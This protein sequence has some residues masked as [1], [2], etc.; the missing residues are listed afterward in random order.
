MDGRLLIG[1]ILV[2]A[3][4]MLSG[5]A[6]EPNDGKAYRLS[7]FENPYAAGGAGGS[8]SEAATA[9]TTSTASTE[10][11]LAVAGE[12]LPARSITHVDANPPTTRRVF[13]D[14]L[15]GVFRSLCG[16]CHVEGNQG[17]WQVSRKTFNLKRARESL[18]AMSDDRSLTK[19][20]PP[21]SVGGKLP[22]DR[23]ADDPSVQ[24]IDMLRSYIRGGAM[25]YSY[26]EDFVSEGAASPYRMA[27][28]LADS[29]T[30]LGNCVPDKGL[31]ATETKEMEVMDDL[32]ASAAPKYT[33]SVVEQIGLP[34][35]L[36]ETDLTSFDSAELAK[37]GVVAWT[38]NYP[39]FNDGARAIRHV[40][41]PLGEA[42]TFDKDKQQFAIPDLTRFYKTYLKPVVQSDGSLHWRKMETQLIV[43]WQDAT[44]YTGY[45]A[46]V[47]L[48]GS[49]LW[50]EDE[51]EA[52]LVT[53]PLRDGKA[54]RDHLLTYTSDEVAEA[55]VLKLVE[56]QGLADPGYR[57]NES[58]A[59]HRYAVPGARRCTE[60]HQ[61]SPSKNFVL[62]F[63]P[64]QLKRHAT[65]SNGV[66]EP[67]GE[68]E[69]TQ[70]QR[71]IDYGLL[72]GLAS[73]DDIVNLEDSQ[74]SRKP[75]NN[76]ELVAQGYVMSACAHCHNDRGSATEYNSKLTGA[77]DLQPGTGDT[78]GIFQFPLDRYSE[79][80][81]RGGAEQVR[82]PYITPSLFDRPS[83]LV[84]GDI[85]RPKCGMQVDTLY[86]RDEK[87]T[88]E[89]EKYNPILGTVSYGMV[90]AL[91][92]WRSL[93]YRGVDTPFAYSD[94]LALFPRMPMHTP[95][96]DC[97]APRV[98]AEW[99]ISIPSTNG[100]P[101]DNFPN[102]VGFVD[103][104]GHWVDADLMKRQF[105]EQP[106]VEVKPDEDGFEKAQSL[107]EK[108]LR[109]Y[110]GEETPT[111]SAG[112]SRYTFCPE[113]RDIVDRDVLRDPVKTPVPID[114]EAVVGGTSHSRDNVPNTVHW[115]IQD[116]TL[117]PG[118]WYPRRADWQ[119][120]LQARSYPSGTSEDEKLVVKT[121]QD[122]QLTDSLQFFAYKKR[123]MALW[124]K[125]DNCSF[126]GVP[127]VAS[128][129]TN[130]PQWM[131]L[132]RPSDSEP[133]YRISPGE[134][135]NGLVCAHCHGGKG[136]A[137]GRE[138]NTLNE[139]TG[140]NA[141]VTNF[142]V[143]ISVESNR[144]KVFA[145]S[146]NVSAED[147]AARYFAWMGLG[148][149]KQTIPKSILSLVATTE[150]IG[151]KRG[152]YKPPKDANM[153][154]APRD[155]CRWTLPWDNGNSNVRAEVT[156][157]TSTKLR[158]LAMMKLDMDRSPLIRTNGDEELWHQLC[159][160]D[161]PRPVRALHLE[162][163]DTSNGVEADWVY[164]PTT[165]LY[166]GAVYPP[167]A[168][169]MDHRGNAAN[170]LSEGNLS[171]WCLR[172]PATSKGRE[173][174]DEW[175]QSHPATN[176]ELIPY[177]PKCIVCPVGK[178]CPAS[179]F[180]EAGYDPYILPFT[181]DETS[182][183]FSPKDAH[184]TTADLEQ[185]AVRGAINAGLVAFEHLKTVAASSSVSL[186]PNHDQ[187]EQL[188]Q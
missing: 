134:Y 171:P 154:S 81:F 3:A 185:W 29:L 51:T 9:G 130:K 93:V 13:V 44:G 121:L 120:I 55:E 83:T 145:S 80:I 41:V 150:A 74:G 162:L 15:F 142:L 53:D 184:L 138:A 114:K 182:H 4:S 166:A 165:S 175:R 7:D 45:A 33:G 168:A 16:S 122:V 161:N 10:C 179:A 69:L 139:M 79:S 163:T 117:V 177:C 126:S 98:M 22:Q 102:L 56:K 8:T 20:M 131:E 37:R 173:F 63:Q 170:G 58:S 68:D 100:D 148:G 109:E 28:E 82:I 146:G 12:A 70:V 178:S 111:Y 32:F 75:R 176:G 90:C 85:W 167:T 57:L 160:I 64:L 24:L 87:L 50:N 25:P 14:D 113:N 137:T 34:V 180:C 36:K 46:V 5:C 147:W 59:V 112:A 88:L 157:N 133:V 92:P 52:R 6:A 140:G 62:G 152:N 141:L 108:R 86:V 61:G 23:K 35:N 2:W 60:C 73:E 97:Q 153:L 96:F 26:V 135:V 187:C 39:V 47:S 106:Y 72:K 49:Y 127:T 31:Y 76:Y 186:T 95:G 136:D 1:V 105:T 158:D 181:A 129:A 132:T 40:R 110:R 172:E 103:A 48:F 89:E 115:V 94:D 84:E 151:E 116:A 156:A 159:G 17:D 128:Y 164:Q 119:T 99:M 125:K 19:V 188:A 65:G 38:P 155:F 77:L 144:T 67:T 101:F 107:A 183:S 21:G 124:K 30:A 11:H 174:A 91:A 123:P 143:G 104:G 118:D 54:W 18:L 66:V 71:F 149:T 43:V 42:I 169:V 27:S 78:G